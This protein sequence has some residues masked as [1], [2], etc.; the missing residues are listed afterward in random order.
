M[1][2]MLG[3]LITA[4]FLAPALCVFFLKGKIKQDH[5]IP[6]VHFF[7]KLYKPVL[8]LALRKRKQALAICG[9]MLVIG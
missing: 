1:F 7:Q 3:A 4:L 8:V 9:V 2:A 5:E 6:L